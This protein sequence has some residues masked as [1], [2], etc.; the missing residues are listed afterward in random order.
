VVGYVEKPFKV[1]DLARKI[2]TALKKQADGGI[3]RHVSSGTFIQLLE[4]E[5]KTCTIRLTDGKSGKHGVLFFREG[6][7][8]DARVNGLRGTDAA[9]KIF[10]WD[11]VTLS[12]QNTCSLEEDKIQSDLQAILLE[13]MRLKDEVDQEEEP[14][15]AG[16]EEAQKKSSPT[17]QSKTEKEISKRFSRDTY[18]DISIGRRLVP[19][20]TTDR[21]KSV[22]GSTALIKTLKIFGLLIIVSLTGFL[23]LFITMETEKDL[24]KKIALTKTQIRLSQ[25]AFDRIDEKLQQVWEEKIESIKHKNPQTKIIEMQLKIYE[26]EE[27]QE[28]IRDEINIPKKAL[29]EYLKKLEEV[30]RKSFLQR[31][32]RQ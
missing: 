2:T 6:E 14:A 17:I 11:E 20:T 23:C 8:L 15:A 3:L 13:A 29:E 32:L 31:F 25:E 12:I 19:Y 18:Q 1:E 27:A 21:L 5:Q 16:A 7:L 24:S 26:L 4:M 22:L 10:A 9:Y 30:K 28:K